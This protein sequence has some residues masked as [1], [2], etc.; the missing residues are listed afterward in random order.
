MG[1]LLETLRQAEGTRSFPEQGKPT[2]VPVW[3]PQGEIAE[4]EPDR[5]IP[6]IEVGPRKS[7]EA[8]PGV[9]GEQT[10]GPGRA[11]PKSPQVSFREWKPL[12]GRISPEVVAFHSP[13]DRAGE[14]YRSLLAALINPFP[15]NQAHVLFFT[16][17]Q[18]EASSTAVV[19]NLAV[20]AARQGHNR[21]IVV[22][23]QEAR[24]H[25]AELLGLPEA[26]GLREVFAGM[27]DLDRTLQETEQSGLVGLVTGLPGPSRGVHLQVETVRSVLRQLRQRGDLIFVLGSDWNGQPEQMAWATAADGVCLVLPEEKAHSPEVDDLVQRLTQEK[28]RVMGCVL[29]E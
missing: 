21:V 10:A 17:P 13:A 23:A 2:S 19:L 14:Q 28:A 11:S 20:T 16:S 8:S 22:E 6:F 26:P 25:L 7:L 27:A 29:M 12:R 5:E 9:L 15:G 3:P 24:P 18:P 4:E 1:R